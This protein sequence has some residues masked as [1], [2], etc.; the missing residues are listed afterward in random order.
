[1]ADGL[2]GIAG[3]VA[4]GVVLAAAVALVSRRWSCSGL[5]PRWS[6][7]RASM[8]TGPYSGWGRSR[9]PSYSARLRPLSASGWPRIVSR[10]GP[11]QAA[12]VWHSRGGAGRRL[13]ASG[14][15]GLR[16]AL[17][18]GHGR[19]AVPVRSVIA[20]TVLAVFVG[21]AT[22]TFGASL[23]T[24]ISHPSLYGWN[25]SYA[26]Y[27]VD[28]YGSVPSRW[29]A[30]L[31]A[32]DRDVAATTGVYFATVQIDGQTVPAMAARVPAAIVPS[33]L[34]G[35][36]LTGPGQI[37][38]GPATLAALHKRL[39]ETVTVSEGQIVPPVRLRITGTAALP[40]IGDVIGVHASLS[41]GALLSTQAV[42]A[43]D[44]DAYG[45]V[46]GPNAIFIRLRPGVTPAAGACSLNQIADQLNRD[47]RSPAAESVIGDQGSY[48][49]FI[50]VLPVQRPAEIVNYKSMGAMP[51]ILAG[52]LAAGAI[53]GLGLTLIA[54]VRRRRH[55]LALLKTLGFTRGQLAAAV[56]WQAATI[57]VIGVLIRR[58]DGRRGR[59]LALAGV[60][61]S[62]VRGTGP[63]RA[64]R[65]DRAGRSRRAGARQPRRRA[66]WPVGLPYPRGDAVF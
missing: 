33:S 10:A 7:H 27:S 50:S 41:T 14:A 17:E 35:H 63:G 1:M 65:L 3:A 30:P 2:L 6:L 21:I 49:K 11:R 42:P 44:L 47:S 8:P 39:G 16:F 36:A 45:P 62:A 20:G 15:A 28:G 19:T 58:A 31:L 23:S 26:L 56:G 24:L 59:A 57:A 55:D 46:S 43:R 22:L 37:V 54:S 32:R 66:A 5:S 4:T 40:T 61:A 60:R 52:G 29:A 48:I 53:A 25:F 34:T 9:W 51:A 13:P 64:G 18:P 12:G 38:L